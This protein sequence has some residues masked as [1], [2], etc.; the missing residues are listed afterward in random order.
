MTKR[1]ITANW[2]CPI[3]RPP[4][5]DGA[6]L[7]D[8]EFIRGVGTAEAL[9][10]DHPDVMVEDLGHTVVTPGLVNA[11]TH[12]ALTAAAGLLPPDEFCEWLARVPPVMG[13]WTSE[14]LAA[15]ATMGAL[16]S[17]QAGV[18]V[19]GEI[20]YDRAAADAVLASGLGATL[21]WEVLG[22]RGE[23]LGEKL[24]RIG[25]P[26]EEFAGTRWV[27]GISPHAP[28]TAG[29]SLLKET[30]ALARAKGLP[31][32]IHVAESVAETNLMRSGRGPL[33]DVA[34]RMAPDFTP[35]GTSTVAYLDRL[36][37]LKEA[38]AIHVCEASH[39][40]L[41]RLA[42]SARG[43]VVCPRSNQWLH[44]R[45]APAEQIAALGV[46]M[47][48]GTDSAASNENLDLLEDVRALQRAAPR[49]S[50]S[51]LLRSVTIDGAFVIGL[52]DR[53]GALEP[54]LAADLAVFD[55]GRTTE[56]EAA[57]V[58]A[59]GRATLRSVMTAGR[60]RIRDGAIEDDAGTMESA[61]LAAR[62]KAAAAL[63]PAGR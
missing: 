44:N 50:A 58:R 54:Y 39:V 52:G 7:I 41:V 16:E 24:E 42:A 28:Y 23:H 20:V 8:G 62:N 11:H 49:L 61:A 12:L 3:T 4:I 40:D 59:G 57:V 26:T 43:V 9:R 27:T 21:Y 2:I 5:R 34:D 35:P 53:F 14:D 10:A 31:Y 22:G 46:P 48:V 30:H 13:A 55:L 29:P 15:S 37:V 36:G 38:L 51:Q 32:A 63:A 33:A 1:L 6:V 47:A 45:R 18:T 19:V 17:L 60:W 56:P 25:F